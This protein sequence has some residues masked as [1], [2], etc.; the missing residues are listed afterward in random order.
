MSSHQEETSNFLLLFQK[1]VLE[2]RC[3]MYA[4]GHPPQ[5]NADPESL[6]PKLPNP[7]DLRPFPTMNT[8]EYIGHQEKIRS[9][10]VSPDGQWLVTGK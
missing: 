8:I 10:S 5:I 3:M 7:R 2:L 1:F 9:L 4:D 6:I